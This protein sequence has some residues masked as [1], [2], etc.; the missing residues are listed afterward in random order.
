MFDNDCQTSHCSAFEIVGELR[1]RCAGQGIDLACLS[2]G[3][4]PGYPFFVDCL[5]D[6]HQLQADLHARS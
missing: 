3:L 5:K 6:K 1:A 4:V 2:E